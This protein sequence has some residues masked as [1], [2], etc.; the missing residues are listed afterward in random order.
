MKPYSQAC[1]NNREPILSVIARLFADRK[2][3]LEIGSGTGQ[4]AV[5]FAQKMPNLIWQSSDRAENHPGIKLWLQEAGL[6]NTPPPIELDVMQEPWPQISADAVFSANTA[7]IMPWASVE[8]ML[9]IIAAG[10][11]NN[12]LFVLYGPF[13]YEGTYTSD[14][15]A[16]FD[17]WLQ[18]RDSLSGIRDFEAVNNLANRLQLTLEEDIEMPAN[19]RILSWRKSNKQ[20]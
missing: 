4:H 18:Q 16:S 5:Y 10:L 14:S 15:N 6:I 12:G 7:H 3:I 17:Q 1:V 8:R 2:E 20:S 11:P 19:N 13:N 9:T